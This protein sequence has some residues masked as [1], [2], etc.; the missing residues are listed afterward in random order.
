[1]HLVEQVIPWVP[2]RQWVASVPIP[3]GY[4]PAASKERMVQVHTLIRR[5]IHHYDVNPAVKQ[6]HQRDQVQAGSITFV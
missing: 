6:G 2:T 4:W 5:T 3:L 1:V